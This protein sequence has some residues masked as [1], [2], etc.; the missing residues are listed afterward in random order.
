MFSFGGFGLL[1][2]GNNDEIT[3]IKILLNDKFSIKD[4]VVLKHYLCFE[5]S[6]SN[7][8]ITLCQRKYTLDLLQDTD[9]SGVKPCNTP[10]LPHLYFTKNPVM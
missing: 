7:E 6:R 3:N 1:F 10:M 4:L 5:V 9:L 8:G 2:L